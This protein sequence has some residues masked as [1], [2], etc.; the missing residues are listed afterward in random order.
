MIKTEGKTMGCSGC[1]DCCK[2]IGIKELS[3]KREKHLK[4]TGNIPRGWVRISRRQAKKLNPFMFKAPWKGRTYF[5]CTHLVEEGCSI[6]KTSPYVCSGYPYY[7]RGLE[8]LTKDFLEPGRLKEYSENCHLMKEVL[9]IQSEEEYDSWLLGNFSNH[10]DRYP[11]S[12]H[13][14]VTEFPH[15]RISSVEIA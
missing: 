6:H 13:K 5:K 12:L 10:I 9:D 8:S 4:D 1:T 14:H 3:H 11:D 2:A 15:R 7:G